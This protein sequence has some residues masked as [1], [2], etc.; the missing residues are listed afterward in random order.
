MM[1]SLLGL[2]IFSI[3]MNISMSIIITTPCGSVALAD[4]NSSG[5]CTLS[6]DLLSC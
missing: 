1:M 3:V 4:C 6:S 5:Y 2:S